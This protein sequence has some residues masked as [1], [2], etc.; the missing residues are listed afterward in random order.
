MIE[1]IFHH[2]K[3]INYANVVFSKEKANLI[4]I[5]L[6]PLG[7]LLRDR[8]LKERAPMI[9]CLKEPKTHQ[10][11]E[12]TSSYIKTASLIQSPP[13][14][15]PDLIVVEDYTINH[16]DLKRISL[17][18]SLAVIS[19]CLISNSLASEAY[20]TI[21]RQRKIW[22]MRHMSNPGNV[23]LTNP[24]K[25]QFK[26]SVELSLKLHNYEVPLEMIEMV[27]FSALQGTSNIIFTMQLLDISVISFLLDGLAHFNESETLTLHRRLSPYHIALFSRCTH[28]D[29]LDLVKLV[30]MDCDK[31]GLSILNMI[32]SDEQSFRYVDQIGVP[33]SLVL[34]DRTFDSGLLEL[35]NRSTTLCETIHL[36]DIPTYLVKIMQSM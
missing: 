22:W 17:K 35:R 28:P 13:I 27:P 5:K 1:S 16:D 3:G 33:Y 12:W 29:L 19:S 20:F 11:R 34:D 6:L 7:Q 24:Q 2:L 14:T 25:E 8:I 23:I 15:I 4:A 10:Y 32:N 36:S 18:K 30:V 26:E 31:N 21:Q 9:T